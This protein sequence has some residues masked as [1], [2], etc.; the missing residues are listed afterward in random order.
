MVRPTFGFVTFGALA[1][2]FFVNTDPSWRHR[3]IGQAMTTAAL[4]SARHAGAS[5]ACLD[6]SAAAVSIYLR[7]GFEIV[8]RSTQLV[9]A[10]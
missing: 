7:L 6:A 3:G 1:T 2:V 9:R 4:R 10:G 8:A 5:Q